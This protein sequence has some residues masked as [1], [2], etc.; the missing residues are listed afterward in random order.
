[1]WFAIFFV[2]FQ[3]LKV[4]DMFLDFLSFFFCLFSWIVIFF[5]ILRLIGRVYNFLWWVRSNFLSFCTFYCAWV[6]ILS[7]IVIS[8]PCMCLWLQGNIFSFKEKNIIW[9]MWL[10]S[11]VIV[12]FLAMHT[13]RWWY[14][15]SL[16]CEAWA[17]I[18]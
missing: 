1:L 11:S 6:M 10:Y 14:L 9:E 2:Y 3:L 5:I 12:D 7:W 8:W 13:N 16:I 15:A 18:N 4:H 17:K